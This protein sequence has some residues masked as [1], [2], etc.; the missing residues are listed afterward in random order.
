MIDPWTIV[1]WYIVL[2][3]G[4]QTVVVIL[5]TFSKS[6][7]SKCVSCGKNF[8]PPKDSNDVFSIAYCEKC[9]KKRNKENKK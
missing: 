5:K 6:K 3:L 2:L 9:L 8:T 1:G 4:L 7:G